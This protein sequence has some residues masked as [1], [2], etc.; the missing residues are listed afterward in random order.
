MILLPLE[1]RRIALVTSW[2]AQARPPRNVGGGV[3]FCR[4]ILGS[5]RLLGFVLLSAMSLFAINGRGLAWSVG[6]I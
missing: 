3:F 1:W 6:D 4:M 2:F 5:L